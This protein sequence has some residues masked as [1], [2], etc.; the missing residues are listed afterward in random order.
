MGEPRCPVTGYSI[1][2]E[3]LTNQALHY[4]VVFW[5][6]ISQE[7]F[8]I[9]LSLSIVITAKEYTK[10]VKGSYYN[11]DVPELKILPSKCA[12]FV[13]NFEQFCII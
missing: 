10:E 7:Y 9:F 8:T 3:G 6:E 13:F 4:T 5:Y 2:P 12:D 11:L 1:G